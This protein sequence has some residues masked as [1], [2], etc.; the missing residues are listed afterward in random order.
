MSE[1]TDPIR[2][3]PGQPP[4]GQKADGDNQKDKTQD[5]YQDFEEISSRIDKVL[6]ADAFSRVFF[7][8]TWARNV[9][10]YAG[11][12]WLK[13]VGGR[14]ER[15][16]LPFWFPRAMT[17]KFAE[18]ANDLITQLLQGG[19]VPITYEPAS[20]DPADVGTADVGARIREVMYTEAKADEQAHM[21]A[22]WLVITGN[23]FGI[24]HYDMDKSHGTVAVPYQLCQD[25]G[26]KIDPEEITSDPPACP[27]CG[28]VNLVPATDKDGK[29][30]DV[31][32][33]YPIGALQMEVCGPFE[34]RGD[35][36]IEVSRWQNFVRQKKY[37]LN[38]AKEKWSDVA[39]NI[40][41]DSGAETDT[42]SYFLDLFA[43]LTPDFAFGAGLGANGNTATKFPKVTAYCIHELP[44]EKYPQGLYAIRLGKNPNAI[45]DAGPLPTEYGAGVKKGQKFLNLIHFGCNIV[46]G[47]MWR[48]TP[49]DDLITLQVFRN[50]IE[51]NIRLSVQRMGNS[52]WLLPKGCGVDI[53]TGEPGQKVSYNPMSVGGTQMAKPERIPADLNNLGSLIAMLK[54][55]DD[56]MERVAGTF[57]LQGGNAP[58]GVTAA[59]ALAYL[60]E[61]GQQSLSTLRTGWAL[62]WREFDRMGLEIARANWDDDRIRA[63]AGKNKKW[64]VSK[65]SKA[66][67]QGAVN[68]TIDWNA[69]APKSNATERATIGQL[70]QLG[71]VQPQDEEMQV[72][73]LKKFGELDLKGSLSIDIEDAAKEQDAF[74]TQPEFIP[75]VRPFVDN[76]QVHFR[77]H[78]DFAKTDEFRELPAARQQVWLKHIENTVEDIVIRRASLTQAGLDPDVPALAEVPSGAAQ[79]AAEAAQAAQA[80]AAAQ[81]GGV[82]NGAE[83]PDARLNPDGSAKEPQPMPD[84]AA[85]G[86]PAPAAGAPQQASPAGLPPEINPPG[87][88][89]R[90]DMPATQ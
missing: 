7:E 12:Q 19:R 39:D 37:D 32:H 9:F 16:N 62:G 29:A 5:P 49:M 21:L 51:A 86:V 63:V 80:A 42:S 85:S 4:T 90:I 64:Q 77:E 67:I 83:G 57:F 53:L 40:Q 25:C 81:N 48:K 52:I 66:D 30:I 8:N 61:K 23:A 56:A 72:Q 70:V 55:I 15:R 58:P 82:P 65:F 74:L 26:E 54:V 33:D 20:D 88:P 71:F 13:K 87:S 28:S 35:H 76:S 17:N 89:R 84:I 44:S 36:R 41:P 45:V 69:L 50:M 46:P 38:W 14:W 22:S 59:S 27:K 24:P 1:N 47:R 18:K 2:E 43:N 78:V 10:F 3:I 73:V 60:G 75:Q 34:I 6:K 68:F 79:A 11:A 31:A